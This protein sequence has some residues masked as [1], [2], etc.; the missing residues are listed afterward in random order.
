MR[1]DASLRL[2]RLSRLRPCVAADGH[3]VV[4]RRKPVRVESATQHAARVRIIMARHSG[5][6]PRLSHTTMLALRSTR[7]AVSS[8]ALILL[9]HDPLYAQQKSAAK[10][11]AQALG[12][13]VISGV[14]GRGSA[15]AG[16]VVDSTLLRS[17]APGTSAL[18]VI[19]KLPGVNMQSVDGFG[20]YEWANRITMRGFQ[21]AQIGQTMDGVPLGDMSYGN[22]N[23]LGI[24]RAVDATNIGSTAVTQ[25]TG[26]LGTASGNNLGGVV[27]YST[28]DPSGRPQF[29]LQQMGGQ[30]SARRTTLRYDLG[31]KQIGE[32]GINAFISV[33][34]FDTDKWKGGGT[35]YS[36]F[37]GNSSLLFGQNGFIGGAGQT[38][39]EQVNLKVNFFAGANKLTFFYD[40]ADRKE[41]DYMDLSLSVFNN[42]VQ[43]PGVSFGP[44]FD[45]LTSW[46]QAKTFATNASLVD[47]SYFSSA[48]GARLDHLAYLRGE[49]KVSDNARI[50]VQPYFHMDRGGGDWHAPSYGASYS[51][52]PIMFRQSQ[53]HTNRAGLL[54]KLAATF[55]TGN[56]ANA[57]EVGGWYESNETNG[58]RPRW[59]VANYALGPD[60]DFNNVLRLD[61]DRTAQIKTTVFY[62][63]NTSRFMDDRL[64]LS[65]GAKYLHVD[66]DFVNNGNTPTNGIVAPIFADP[67]RPSLSAPT[68]GG[69]LPQVG[70]V[71][72]LDTSNELF[73]NVSQNVNQFPYSPA[74][75]VYNANP[76]TFDFFKNTAK[77][78]KATT[79]EIGART[80]RGPIEAGLTGYNIDYKNRLLGIALCPATV[81]CATGFGN[82]GSVKTFGVEGVM[83]ADLGNGF[84]LY[85]S[86]SYNSS[87]F[88]ENYLSN[89]NDPKS[90][91]N[92]KDKNVQDAPQQLANA[93]LSYSEKKFS[94]SLG[95]RFVGE[96]YFT[97]TNDLNVAGD[98]AGKVPGYLVSDFS[99]RYNLGKFGALR[100]LDVQFNMNNLLDKKYVGTMGSNGYGAFGDNQTLLTGAPRQMFLTLS[101]TF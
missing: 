87:K 20:M 91:V 7:V 46:A 35:R 42:S 73:A 40:Y 70:A 98:A 44:S 71:F 15:R 96:R 62:A 54:T 25:G 84:R 43:A 53:Y 101:T 4:T 38:W 99:A 21:T 59:R 63:Q 75:G 29:L 39:H 93:S 86:A 48:Q 83:N 33:S 34:R 24:G 2:G 9:I 60:V 56:V 92:T 94:A 16:G 55:N 3:R 11:S 58:R 47:A 97:Y 22:F 41:S 76:T 77:N 13:V 23:G 65:Y 69:I 18:K 88:G 31:L 27:Q 30:N 17:A 61:F 26:A 100:S 5:L 90:L 10:D 66:A 67:T 95:G 72:K 1:S 52:D 57:L 89:Q 85:A 81:T 19:E 78:E 64:S 50:E 51:P 82:V 37:P 6:G 14:T 68:K 79:M 80:R 12:K 74:G 8:A 28:S 49:F 45:Y 36:S 32:N